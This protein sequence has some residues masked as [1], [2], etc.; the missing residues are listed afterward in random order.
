MFGLELV[1][2]GALFWL[3]LFGVLILCEISAV[4]ETHWGFLWLVLFCGVLWWGFSS[5]PFIWAMHNF[6]SLL[7]YCGIYLLLGVMWGFGKWYFFL[8]NALDRIMR[9]ENSLRT[10]YQSRQAS[11]IPFNGSFTQY[12]EERGRIPRAKDN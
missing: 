8:R 12:L 9:E 2:G 3:L 11:T 1:V 6:G 7:I 4:N 5:N 10:D